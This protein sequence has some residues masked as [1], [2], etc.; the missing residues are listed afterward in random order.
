M[1]GKALESSHRR[2][3]DG[4]FTITPQKKSSQRPRLNGNSSA[5]R[6]NGI[7]LIEQLATFR[8]D[9]ASLTLK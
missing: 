8:D 9:L 4:V 6:R 3:P 2:K 7:N 5:S 1:F